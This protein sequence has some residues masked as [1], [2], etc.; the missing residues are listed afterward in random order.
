MPPGQ[1]NPR[2]GMK[3]LN[4]LQRAE[5]SAYIEVCFEQLAEQLQREHDARYW[6]KPAWWL[7]LTGKA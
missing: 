4:D 3:S 6:R 2:L 1:R 7:K 5:V